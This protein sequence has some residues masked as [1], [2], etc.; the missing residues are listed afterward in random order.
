[1][2]HFGDALIVVLFL[3]V[4]SL[5]LAANLSGVDG[6]DA[7][8][9]NRELAALPRVQLSWR[10]LA[11]YGAGL[12]RWFEDHFGFRAQLVRW[13]GESRM[14]GL[15]VSPT[16]A[17]L[18]GR[19]GWL[20][21]AD[22]GG[23]ED[24]ANESP[25]TADAVANWR[26]T[27]LRARD[28]CRWHGVAY[29]FTVAPDKHAVYPEM[30]PDTVRQIRPTSR[31]DQVL[32]GVSDTGVAVDVRPALSRAKASERLYHLTDTHWNERGAFVAY[33]QII[34]A[35]R[36]QDRRVPA[37]WDRSD[38]VETSRK[39]VGTDLVGM[40]LARMM[41]LSH[42]LTENVL[43][44]APKRP[45]RAVVTEPSAAAPTAEEGRLVT[46]IPGSMLPRAVI[47]RDSFGSALV[48]FLSEH[49]SRAVYLWQNDFDADAV[50][51][52]NADVVIQEIAGR[53]LHTF[54]PTPALV[55]DP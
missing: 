18:R 2:R 8:A 16:P 37:A 30:F 12:S 52:E 35:V 23:F 4:I 47:F 19:D 50:Q 33:Q 34:A 3:L 28:W 1:M 49:F 5:P 29:V 25:L 6:A 17:V 39:V 41:G 32:D 15:G 10:G 48:P 53:H 27:V 40:D 43:Q 26:T 20:F 46:E 7:A 21:Y 38:F 14:F 42:V 22:D 31:T 36:A 55:P 11:T 13:Y 51:R 54:I 44:L 9:E 45:R 24:F